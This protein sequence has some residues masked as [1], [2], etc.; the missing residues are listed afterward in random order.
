MTE[1]TQEKKYSMWTM[2]SFGSKGTLIQWIN[3]AFGVYVF[4]FYEIYVGLRSELAAAAFVIFAIWNAFNDPLIGY[5]MEKKTFRW[6]R[7]RGFRRFP[8]YIIAIPFWLA[9][10]F[11][12]FLVPTGWNASDPIEQWFIF[13]WYIVSICLYDF[14]FS[15]MDV[16]SLSIYP[17]KFS[18]PR[19][20]KITQ[21]FVAGMGILGLVMAFTIPGFILPAEAVAADY[22][23]LSWISALI[24]LLLVI[25]TIPGHFED[26]H[27]RQKNLAILARKERTE[28]PKESFGKSIGRVM[29][30]RNFIG[31]MSIFFGCQLSALLIQSGAL[32]ILL[33][34]I[35]ETPNK[36]PIIL[37]SMLGGALVSIPFWLWGAQKGKTKLVCIIASILMT[38]SFV[39]MIFATTVPFWVICMVLFGMA[40]GGQWFI[41]PPMLTEIMDDITAKTG[42]KETSVV[43]GVQAFFIRFNSALQALIFAIVHIT[44][45]FIEGSETLLELQ[46]ANPTGWQ[47]AV[48]GIQLHSIIIPLGIMIIS[49]ILFA[50]LYRLT[51]SKAAENR[52]KVKEMQLL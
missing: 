46:I 7:K 34:V 9:S 32:Y 14:L 11:L 2:A 28:E 5:T 33:F 17:E 35:G 30:N 50:S 29:K 20:R 38:L 47:T 49:T 21:A 26:K 6:H 12:I 4:A 40:I 31:K 10:Y 37:G 22:R 43:W 3:G 13:A 16:N 42:K 41:D 45:G 51:P 19:S 48:F 8:W 23:R 44:T 25:P 15:L 1:V 27:L 18:D 24:G 39:P 36:L 52:Q